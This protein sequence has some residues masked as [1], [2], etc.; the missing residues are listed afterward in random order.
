MLRI[1]HAQRLTAILAAQNLQYMGMGASMLGYDDEVLTSVCWAGSNIVP[2]G[3]TDAIE[4]FAQHLRRRGRRATSLV[5]RADLVLE[6]WG[7]LEPTWG[8]PREVRPNQPCLVR[9]QPV[10]GP[11]DERV[12]R[13]TPQD[14]DRL[15]PAAVAMF[16]E[17]VGYDPTR[18]GSGYASYVRSLAQN[19]RSYIVTEPL[20]GEETVVFKADIGALWD[21]IAQIQGVWV[22]PRLRGRGIATAAMAAVTNQILAQVAPTVSLYVNDYNDAA[23]RVYEKVGYEQQATYATVLI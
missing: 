11:V 21:N 10:D 13:A 8:Q 4:P 15:F 23:R 6:M 7:L 20:D 3:E 17:E 1:L 5:G 2:V 9:E 19:G 16:T 22:H 18:Q 14:Y 12:R